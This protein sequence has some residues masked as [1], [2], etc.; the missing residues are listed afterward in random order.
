MRRGTRSP[1]IVAIYCVFPSPLPTNTH[2]HTNANAYQTLPFSSFCSAGRKEK[3]SKEGGAEGSIPSSPPCSVAE[4][5]NTETGEILREGSNTKT[6]KAGACALRVCV[7]GSSLH[8]GVPV[9]QSRAHSALSLSFSFSPTS[10]S[11]DEEKIQ[12]NRVTSMS[13][14]YETMLVYHRN[15]S[16]KHKKHTKKEKKKRK[17]WRYA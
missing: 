15:R 2:A 17:Q 13:L 6:K 1:F 7:R 8:L 5:Q 11:R 9:D 10:L 16:R 14:V 4:H 12:K 3:K